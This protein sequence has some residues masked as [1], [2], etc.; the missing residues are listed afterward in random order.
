MEAGIPAIQLF[1]LQFSKTK[2]NH[3][4][5]I[6]A[7]VWVPGENHSEHPVTVDPGMKKSHDSL[8]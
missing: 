6:P 5:C 3:G 7:I 4:H 8:A 2:R 1:L